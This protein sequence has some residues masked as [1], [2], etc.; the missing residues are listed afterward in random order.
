MGE[1]RRINKERRQRARQNRPKVLTN[2]SSAQ[3]HRRY[4]AG[5]EETRLHSRFLAATCFLPL[6][7]EN[8]DAGSFLEDIVGGGDMHLSL[9]LQRD[10]RASSTSSSA[11]VNERVY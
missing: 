11:E 8:V 9:A 2:F 4:S 5:A 7:D 3:S 6:P 1:R 10:V